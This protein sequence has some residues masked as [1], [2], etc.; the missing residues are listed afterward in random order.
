MNSQKENNIIQKKRKE[1]E[2]AEAKGKNYN[3]V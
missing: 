1:R 2:K 3:I